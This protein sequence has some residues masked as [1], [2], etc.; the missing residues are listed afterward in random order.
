MSVIGDTVGSIIGGITGANQAAQAQENAANQ[1]AALSEQQF[2]K[3]EENLAPYRKLGV[4][5]IGS[6]MNAAKQINPEQAL[7]DF[8]NSG[9][10]G[11]MSAQANN[12]LMAQQEALG[13]LGSSSIANS[14]QRVAPMLG[15]QHL[16]QLYSRQA[17]DFNRQMGLVG[18]GQNAA[19]QT[20]SA[21]QNYASQA[22]QAYQ[23][24]GQAQAMGAMAPFQT[25]MGIGQMAA[26]AYGGGMF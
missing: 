2:S 24:A 8:Y 10:Y 4:G 5:S 11:M 12:N 7:G 23:Q 21:G 1:A 22:G 18:L 20:G 25:L 15:Q 26:G 14:L 13:G 3:L 9:E 19:A 6:L 17:D 16:G